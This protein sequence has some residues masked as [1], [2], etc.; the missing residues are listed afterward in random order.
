MA[1]TTLRRQTGEMHASA[2]AQAKINLFL[3]VG[4]LKPDGFHEIE[5]LFQLVAL[6]D[7]VNVRVHSKHRREIFCRGTNVPIENNLALRAATLYSEA[8]EWPAGFSIEI[9]KRIP[10]GAGL[11]G[12]SSDASAV[13]RILNQLAPEPLGTSELFDLGLQLG[14]DVPFFLSGA[15]LA[16]ASGRGE[17]LVPL[18]PLPA[19]GV[20][21]F[22]LPFPI[23][24][25]DAY[26]WI[27][28]ARVEAS[29]AASSTARQ[30]LPSDV[31]S[32]N[33]VARLA[34]ND[35]EE[36]ISE[37]HPDL[38]VLLA[39]ARSASYVMAEMTGSGSTVFAVADGPEPVRAPSHVSQGIPQI[40]TRTVAAAE[41][42]H[43]FT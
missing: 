41:G 7:D 11:G 18:Q 31:A 24:T 9:T 26:N 19:R 20:T 4:N 29:E 32:W 10:I 25:R 23:S 39:T 15:G 13:L 6:G 5:T 8:Q 17:K 43:A 33:D 42:I 22:Q 1:E 16:L 12:G 28:A 14:S 38:A 27:D 3:R 37:R 35:F 36:V 34:Q 2:I 21:L 40:L 30:V